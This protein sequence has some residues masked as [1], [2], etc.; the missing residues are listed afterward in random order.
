MGFNFF[1]KCINKK[2]FFLQSTD[3]GCFWLL[4]R[5]HLNSFLPCEQYAY[6]NYLNSLGAT[7]SSSTAF[8]ESPSWD[9]KTEQFD[10]FKDFYSKFVLPPPKGTILKIWLIYKIWKILPCPF[11]KIKF[12][13]A[14]KWM[15][16]AILAEDYGQ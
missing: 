10:K 6:N 4:V 15:F 1:V 14:P 8:K 9:G 13:N 5:I 16:L 3:T 11:L 12:E 2:S 7:C